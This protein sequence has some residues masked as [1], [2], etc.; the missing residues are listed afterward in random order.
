MIYLAQKERCGW[1][2]GPIREKWTFIRAWDK[3]Q[4]PKPFTTMVFLM[5]DP[6]E[7]PKDANIEEYCEI[8][9]IN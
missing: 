1:F 3:F 6:I 7:I 2:W 4:F 8:L 9:K 5:G